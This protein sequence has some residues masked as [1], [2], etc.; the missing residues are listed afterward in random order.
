M[1]EAYIVGAEMTAFGRWPD[2]T[3]AELGRE[4]IKSLLEGLNFP[5]EEVDAAFVG[6]S[7][8]GWIDGQVSIPG[9]VA[10]RGTGVED[11]P[12]L[13]F[14]NAC[15]A[16]PSAL[17]CATQAV[18]SGQY[19]AVLVV[20]MDKLYS[21]SRRQ[22]MTAL[23]GALDVRENGWM[24][25]GDGEK[26]GSLFMEAY[27][28]K[29]AR[30]YLE[31]T[32]ASY[33]DL[34]KVAVKNRRHAALNPLAQYREPITEQEVL[35]S[36][37]I[38]APLTR[39]MCSPL[40]DGAGALLVCSEE[41][42]KMFPAPIRVAATVVRSGFSE[43]GSRSPV[44]ERAA[45]EAYSQAQISPSDLD[46]VEVHDA[47]AVAELLAVEQLGLATAPEVLGMLREGAT[48]LGGKVPVNPSGG[49]LSR[50]HP[51][52]GTGASQLV[53]VVHQLQQKCGPR[54]VAGAK[55][56]LT[57]TTGGLIGDEPACMAIV[58]LSRD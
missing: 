12:V 11:R 52:A 48:E 33:S 1:A 36:P 51:G 27:Y 23:L 42:A 44:M 34:A 7:F 50:G 31:R 53:E 4:A 9:Q 39:L 56:G 46:L 32:G 41:I 26:V 8:G 58:I 13:N 30:Q 24:V 47:S 21:T 19:K 29:I 57:Q 43:L 25:S 18:R 10:L 20:G 28:A 15:A 49:L 3:T 38:A 5:A 45:H 16:A 55:Y 40:T 14:D 6:R 35:D 17:S 22:S 37:T 54:Q 2:K